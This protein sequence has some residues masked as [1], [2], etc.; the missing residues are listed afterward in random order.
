V[1]IEA[2][3]EFRISDL[4][5]EDAGGETAVSNP[6]FH[7][8][9]RPHSGLSRS[10]GGEARCRLYRLPRLP[11][12]VE[13]W[14]KRGPFMTLRSVV[15]SGAVFCLLA[16][17][18]NAQLFRIRDRNRGRDRDRNIEDMLGNK[19][20]P[21]EVQEARSNADHAYQQGEYAKVIDLTNWLLSAFPNDNAHFAY[22]LRASANIELGKAA[23]SAKQV[24]EGISDAR[25]AIGTA[26]AKF[27]WLHIPYVY[28]LTALAEIERRPEHA[29]M[30]IKAVTP[31]LAYPTTKEFTE[32][33]RA[34]L[35]YQRGLAYG[36]MRDFK[37][38]ES[39]YTEAVKLNAAHLGAHIKRAEALAAHGQT[40]EALAAYDECV[41][42][43]PA[44]LLVYND[45][46]NFRR[47]TGDLDGA[48]SD[49]TRCLAIDAK[50]AVGYINRGVC[51]AEQN[52]PQTAEGDYSEALKLKLD[53]GTANLARRLRGA[54]RLAQG[55]VE[56]SL[57]DFAAAIKAAPQEAALYEE[58][59]FAQY[60]KKDFAAAAADFARARELQPQLTHL[61]PWQALAETRAGRTAEARPLLEAELSGKNAPAGW[62]G[63]ICSFLLD[64]ATDQELLEAAAEG[65][66]R[67][68]NRHV[69]EAH[70]FIGQKQLIRE[71]VTA[72]ADHFRETVASR[73]FALAAFRGARYELNDFK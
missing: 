33:D 61:V 39:D 43:F 69:C 17:T 5:F 71:D 44:N 11:F 3:F 55:N 48:I 63:K 58:R 64:Q 37:H 49:F 26:G 47:T 46:G 32:E 22:H 16:S 56:A 29:E 21:P 72:A 52:S 62:S 23:R 27:P 70:F 7:I 42:E 35:Y 25:T 9:N 38:A 14:L 40:K 73:E 36:A 28:G 10:P 65:T 67:D 60:F 53:P 24:R 57:A 15:I 30:A 2:H 31:V 12:V 4:G 6:Q 18:A 1:G 45:R 19:D 8:R 41:A 13:F 34:N 66:A 59:G 50:F 54:A 20:S 68:K 51:L